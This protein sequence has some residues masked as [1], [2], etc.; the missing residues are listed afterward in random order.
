MTSS[1]ATGWQYASQAYD[2]KTIR[3]GGCECWVVREGGRQIVAPRGTDDLRD[4]AMD[5]FAF[6]KRESRIGWGHCGFIRG[7]RG[8]FDK[9]LFGVLTKP[10]KNNPNSQPI[11]FRGHSLGGAL[12]QNLACIAIAEGFNVSSVITYGSPMPFKKGTAKKWRQYAK[13]HNIEWINVI[14][15]GDPITELPFKW[16]N[17]KHVNPVLT[18]RESIGDFDNLFKKEYYLDHYQEAYDE[19]VMSID[20]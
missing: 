16:W 2:F 10:E 7:A 9:G 1:I 18:N 14:N 8:L 17:Y 6:P 3:V 13:Q 5:L 4:V 12:A 19:G 11:D 15:P 20:S